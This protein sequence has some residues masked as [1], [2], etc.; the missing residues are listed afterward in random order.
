MKDTITV[1]LS[2]QDCV[3]NL[4]TL[5]NEYANLDSKLT[6][7]SVKVSDSSNWSGDHQEKAKIA[8]E[9]LMKYEQS[10]RPLIEDFKSALIKLED[11]VDD[12]AGLSSLVSRLKGW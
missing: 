10:L 5:L 3:N 1:L 4:E 7:L 12:F 6:G 9:M 11:S 8:H 2:I